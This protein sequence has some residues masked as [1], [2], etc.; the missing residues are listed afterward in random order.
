MKVEKYA[1]WLTNDDI[2]DITIISEKNKIKKFALNY[3][4]LIK[5]VWTEIYRVDNYHGFLHEQ[6]FWRSAEPIRLDSDYYLPISIIINKY[7]KI[8]MSNYQTYRELYEGKK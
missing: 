4:A 6:R 5:S 2:I 7:I 1:R 3:R 8:I